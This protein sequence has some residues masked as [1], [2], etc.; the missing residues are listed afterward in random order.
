MPLDGCPLEEL[1]LAA[2]F[3]AEPAEPV[4]P[5]EEP[6]TGG[7]ALADGAD[8]ERLGQEWN[9]VQAQTTEDGNRHAPPVDIGRDIKAA[10]PPPSIKVAPLSIKVAPPSIK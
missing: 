5:T 2:Q 9:R 10:V 4:A 8:L 6:G 7:A 3:A 1:G